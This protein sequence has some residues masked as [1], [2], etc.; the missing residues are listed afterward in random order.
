MSLNSLNL[1]KVGLQATG[2]V[3]SS[4]VAPS[5]AAAAVHRRERGRLLG[6]GAPGPRPVWRPCVG[7]DRQDGVS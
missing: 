4:D 7:G 1:G 6:P 5:V 2:S 3:A